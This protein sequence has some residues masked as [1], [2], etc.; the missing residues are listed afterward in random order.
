MWHPIE[1][2]NTA[3]EGRCRSLPSLKC[4]ADF[5]L[6]CLYKPSNPFADPDTG[7]LQLHY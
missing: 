4:P 1:P 7:I 2:K 5:L 3:V 6:S